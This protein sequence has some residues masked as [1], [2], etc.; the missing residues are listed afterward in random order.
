[1]KNR[2]TKLLR[3]KKCPACNGDPQK[4]RLCKRCNGTGKLTEMICRQCQKKLSECTC[5]V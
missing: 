1:M 2:P 5:K 3:I 4:K